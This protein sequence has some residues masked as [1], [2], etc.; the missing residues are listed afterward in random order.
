MR[1]FLHRLGAMCGRWSL[2]VVAVWV[3][4]LL[5]A[6]WG[7]HEYGGDLS[8]DFSVS[9]SESARGVALLDAKFP[10]QGGYAGTIV[11]HATNGKVTADSGA[12]SKA[13]ARVTDLDHVITASDPLKTKGSTAVSRDGSTVNAPVSFDVSPTTL[14]ESYLH[15]LDDAVAP[16]RSAG[17][18]VE[19]GGGAGQ[20]ANTVD[21]RN[22]E[23]LGAALAFILLLIMF[24][25]VVAAILPLAA[26]A[27]G[28]AT[29]LSV[30]GIIAAS[31]T[32]PTMAPTVATLLGLGV[33][34][35][36]ALFLVA[37]HREQLDAAMDL[38]E[39]VANATATSG[40]AIVVAGGTVML[41]LLG[42]YIAGVSFVGALGLS[43]TVVVGV[44]IV[45]SLTFVPALLRIG[46]SRIQSRR[47][48]RGRHD[49]RASGV[50]A[51]HEHTI[52]ARWGKYVSTRPLRWAVLATLAL[53]LL[54]APLLSMRLGQL[55]A[56]TDPTTDSSRRA[57]D[58]IDEKFG[59]GANGPLVVVTETSDESKQKRQTMLS[60]LQKKLQGTEDVASVGPA[61]TNTNGTV[62][63]FRVIPD[64]SPQSASTQTLVRT[65]RSD[66]LAGD[67]ESAYV[68]GTTASNVDFTDKVSQRMPWLIAVVV[69]IGFALLTAAFR[70]VV[71]G[72]KAAVLNL[73]SIGAAY[74]V[75]VTIFQWGWGSSLIG[76]DET[77]PIPAYVPMFVFAIVFGLSMDYEVFLLS[78]VHDEWLRT[79]D[80]ATSVAIGLGATGRVITTAAAVMVAV[81]T[82]FVFADDPAV[83]MLAV[84]MAVAVL[85]DASIVRML[86]V[87]AIMAMLGARAWWAPPPIRRPLSPT[88]VKPAPAGPQPT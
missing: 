82:S 58:L 12:V 81:F 64:S 27:F 7:R 57:Y 80:A 32:L 40:S 45:S 72:V 48:R 16:A 83:K 59:A 15:D 19:Y 20:I 75:I 17:L 47:E 26:A 24:R 3:V 46:G 21:D 77:V 33:A 60:D 23:I 31:V 86:L 11:F 88:D 29:G 1:A 87:P 28:V 14:D 73:L 41:A 74:G 37:R 84:G 49:D 5:A 39:S 61:E 54:A 78:R 6:L 71:I 18:E 62:A 42:L 79:G 50:D 52:F 38:R 68:V 53:L 69:L 55:D 51:E 30:I 56:G 43:A 44:A 36:Y 70:S 22:S 13:M 9:G 66:V 63:T 85:I 4:V 34:I 35:D 2:A 8:N 10:E 67:S 76:I 65:I 25:S